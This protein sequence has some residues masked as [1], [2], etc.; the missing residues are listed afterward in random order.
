MGHYHEPMHSKTS[1]ENT[2]HGL[3]DLKHL[4]QDVTCWKALKVLMHTDIDIQRHT[5]S[6]LDEASHSSFHSDGLMQGFIVAP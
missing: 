1:R 6:S 4:F 3:E 2:S 5:D